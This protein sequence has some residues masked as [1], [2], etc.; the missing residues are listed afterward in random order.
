MLWLCLARHLLCFHSQIHYTQHIYHCMIKLVTT[1]LYFNLKWSIILFSPKVFIYP[2]KIIDFLLFSV[3]L[4]FLGTITPLYYFSSRSGY[5]TTCFASARGRIHLWYFSVSWPDRREAYACATF[6]PDER[7]N[8][9]RHACENKI[10]W[11]L[12]GLSSSS[13]FSLLDM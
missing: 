1:V 9:P 11:D 10:L 7:S 12:H 4:W 3:K 8:S 2:P 5:C 13:L 6:S